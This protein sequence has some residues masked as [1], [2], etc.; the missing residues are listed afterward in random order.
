MFAHLV[1]YS[2]IK[3]LT[4]Q[5]YV[6]VS[7]CICVF[8]LCVHAC[9]YVCVCVC[10]FGIL[11]MREMST[12]IKLIGAENRVVVARGGNGDLFNGYKITATQDE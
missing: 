5:D 9:V 7:L 10:A 4:I 3:L 11:N 8:V 6:L 1:E 2:Q 12:I